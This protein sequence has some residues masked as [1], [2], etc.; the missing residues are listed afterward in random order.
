MPCKQYLAGNQ[1]QECAQLP[2]A[3]PGVAVRFNS[4]PSLLALWACLVRMWSVGVDFKSRLTMWVG[5]SHEI[6]EPSA[7]V[8]SLPKQKPQL[9]CLLAGWLACLLA[10]T[11]TPSRCLHACL[12]DCL[13]ACLP[14]CRFVC[15]S[16]DPYVYHIGWLCLLGVSVLGFL[17]E[18]ALAVYLLSF[19]SLAVV[20]LGFAV[21]VGPRLIFRR[22]S[23]SILSDCGFVGLIAWCWRGGGGGG[24]GGGGDVDCINVRC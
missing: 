6:S 17:C 11:R 24:G 9:A 3:D 15:L 22:A 21:V 23:N 12:L 7:L 8:G 10:C 14:A 5:R 19:I 18:S 16:D 1:C 2:A 4:L 13:S 20:L